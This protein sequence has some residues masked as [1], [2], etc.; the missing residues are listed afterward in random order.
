MFNVKLAIRRRGQSSMII[1][2][3]IDMKTPRGIVCSGIAGYFDI[4]VKVVML[5]WSDRI[6]LQGSRR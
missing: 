1:R 3:Y 4:K 2:G 5:A 6:N